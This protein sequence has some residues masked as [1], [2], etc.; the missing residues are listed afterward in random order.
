MPGVSPTT[1]CADRCAAAAPAFL[2]RERSV[3][4]AV[5]WIARAG[6]QQ[7]STLG[8][9][10]RVSFLGIPAGLSSSPLTP[11]PR[12]SDARPFEAAVELGGAD[13]SPLQDACAAHEVTGVVGLCERRHGTTGT[14]YN[15]QVYIGANGDLRC[16][17]QKFVPTI[18]ERLVPAPG[19]TGLANSS[20]W[21]RGNVT[22][23]IC[24]E[25]SHPMTQY[26]SALRYPTVHV[27]SWPQHFSPELGMREAIRVASRGLAYS[28][29]CFVINAVATISPEM[30]DSYGYQGA[31]EFLNSESASGR[32]SIVAPWG[33]VLVVARDNSDQMVVLDIDPDA[34]LIPKMVHDVAGHY[35]RPE[36]LRSL[37][38]G[39]QADRAA[40]ASPPTA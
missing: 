21:A 34:V 6:E 12:T 14:L 11:D 36:L 33:E 28:L 37:L 26:T 10:Q 23:L 40:A 27:A 13:L 17:H 9:F 30:S 25:N 38:D 2:D 39:A 7:S 18:G 15:S 8:H 16:H 5:D 24:G 19:S 35:D 31:D 20:A 1:D 3:E 22:S 4:V 29:K 32:A